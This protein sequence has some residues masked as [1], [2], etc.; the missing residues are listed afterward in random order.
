M[1]ALVYRLNLCIDSSSTVPSRSFAGRTSRGAHAVSVGA[2]HVYRIAMAAIAVRSLEVPLVYRWKVAC[3]SGLR[4]SRGLV[5][6]DGDGPRSA[7]TNL[8]D[9]GKEK[10]RA[11]FFHL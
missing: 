10:D 11:A 3:G 9:D 4:L 5:F 7:S 1:Q 8:H 6:A 2:V